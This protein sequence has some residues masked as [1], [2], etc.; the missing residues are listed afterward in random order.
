[1]SLVPVQ[2][3]LIAEKSFLSY[4]ISMPLL[5]E[6]IGGEPPK[7]FFRVEAGKTLG[8]SSADIVLSDVN[9]SG[10]HAKFDL[11][12]KGQF[13]LLDLNSSNGLILNNKKVK[14]VAMLPGV[15]FQMGKTVFIIRQMS[16]EEADQLTPPLSWKDRLKNYFLQT[17]INEQTLNVTY[18]DPAFE[19][20]FVRG[21][22]FEE[23]IAV[24]YGPRIAGSSTW[25][26]ELRDLHA[27]EFAFE[28]QAVAQKALLVNL[29]DQQLTI[30][31]KPVTSQ[32]LETDDSIEIG[33]TVILVKFK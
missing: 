8:R 22:Q 2:A 26:I 21:V 7:Q 17:P 28:L 23:I 29:C 20:E 12:N 25:D 15:K 4:N 24:G 5:I 14:K 3:D 13:I 33:D 1:M 6:V 32:I 18:F 31:K 11:D 19:L 30:N 10:T 27:P 9:I 16:E